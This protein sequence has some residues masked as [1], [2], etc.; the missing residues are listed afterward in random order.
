[1]DKMTLNVYNLATKIQNEGYVKL[2]E[3]NLD[4]ASYIKLMKT[5]LK[6]HSHDHIDFKRPTRNGIYIENP[7]PNKKRK[8]SGL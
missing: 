8:T 5:T 2:H 1:M 6:V 3:Q 7:N 4:E